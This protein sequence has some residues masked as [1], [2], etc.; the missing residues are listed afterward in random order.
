[1]FY[2][3]LFNL[4]EH[5][6]RVM[7]STEAVASQ[8]ISNKPVRPHSAKTINFHTK[9][10]SAHTVAAAT[11]AAAAAGAGSTYDN[12]ANIYDDSES[13][14]QRLLSLRL[15]MLQKQ[16]PI[17][18]KYINNKHYVSIEDRLNEQHALVMLKAENVL[19]KNSNG[20]LLAPT[21]KTKLL[22]NECIGD[23][24]TTNVNEH[25]LNDEAPV[26]TFH[27]DIISHSHS[28]VTTQ[29][30]S[31]SRSQSHSHSNKHHNNHN[32]NNNS[33]TQVPPCT[34]V[35]DKDSNNKNNN[36]DND[37]MDDDDMTQDNPDKSNMFQCC[38]A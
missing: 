16:K 12:G 37:N 8:L 17:N 29:S 23:D 27:H 38:Q 1:M 19:H 34:P 7:S 31:Q 13:A 30:K 22:H 18:N 21:E 33:G 25:M 24:R 14:T 11:A 9:A 6:P 26:V 15:A 32:K 28:H 2:I 4:L 20:L 3:L 35:S 5:M 10:N 36:N